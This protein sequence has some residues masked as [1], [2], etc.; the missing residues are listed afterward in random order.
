MFV[1]NRLNW[2]G[3]EGDFEREP[4]EFRVAAFESAEEAHAEQRRLE[5]GARA[6]VNPLTGSLAPFEHSSMP[7]LVLCDW[8][9]DHGIDPPAPNAVTG[10]RDW[11]GW[12][13]DSSPAW[14]AEQHAAA[15][16]ALDRVRFFEV[17]EEPHLPVAF[18][19]AIA[20]EHYSGPWYVGLERAYREYEQAEEDCAERNEGVLDEE[21]GL[22]PDSAPADPLAPFRSRADPS[23]FED[24]PVGNWPLGTPFYL[25]VPIEVEGDVED[26]LFVV[27]RVIPGHMED[28]EA[29]AFV[30][31]FGSRSAAEALCAAKNAQARELVAP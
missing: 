25:V 9:Q 27:A 13:K 23:D 8:M 19:V 21:H 16:Q 15:W 2:C 30:R 28:G 1:V 7:E 10:R 26:K 18:A 11:A 6:L 17:T 3:M 4:G 12:W 20:D 24:R 29:C 5:E 22:E 14:S 31:G